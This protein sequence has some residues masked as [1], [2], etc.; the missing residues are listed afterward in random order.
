MGNEKFFQIFLDKQI[1]PAYLPRHSANREFAHVVW[2][3]A[4]RAQQ[5]E[6]VNK[7]KKTLTMALA[8]V[9]G[10]AM[11]VQAADQLVQF[12]AGSIDMTVLESDGVSPLA[13]ASIKMLSTED[14][15]VLSETVSDDLGK[16][17][18][19]LEEGR[20]LLNIS[21]VTLAVMDVS[22]DAALTSC[23]VIMPAASMLVAGQEAKEAAAGGGASAS[24]AAVAGGSTLGS[25]VVPAGIIAG[26]AILVGGVW[27][28]ADHQQPSKTIGR[29]EVVPP[30]APEQPSKHKD[31]PKPTPP[32]TPSAIS[33][34]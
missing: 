15:S 31:T 30:A 23:R 19:A 14:N 13:D 9:L 4:G 16:A 29:H 2:A 32:T 8:L 33:A 6:R 25:F 22:P 20:Y 7:M 24:G 18:L 26:A 5:K 27:A 34:I 11:A 12:K 28:V 1:E 17:V 3:T 10:A 21:D